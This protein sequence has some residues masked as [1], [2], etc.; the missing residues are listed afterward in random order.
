MVDHHPDS[1][2]A[3]NT[4]EDLSGVDI[5]AFANPYDALIQ[6]SQNDPARIQNFYGT[7]R[8]TRNEQ[9]RVKLLSPDFSGL[10][11]DPIL[12]KLTDPSIEPG[13]QDPR[14]CIVFWARPPPH[15]R[16]LVDKV[17]QELLALAPNLWV[18]PINN[19]HLTALE[20]T[21]SLTS[22]EIYS[23]LCA[24]G[25]PTIEAMTDY[26]YSHRARLIKP[27]ISYD[28]AA[29]A[30]SFLPAAGETLPS[31]ERTKEDD[32]F[33]YHHLRRD[34]FNLAKS[35]G[36]SVD[37]RY[38]VPS[39]HI[40]LGRFLTQADHDSPEKMRE[41]IKKIEDLNQWLENEWWPKEGEK[42]DGAKEWVVGMEKGLDCRQGTLWYG[43][44]ETVRLGKG[45]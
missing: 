13:F 37:S 31:G 27:M 14:Y 41:W 11:L 12:Q 7:H 1:V 35:T 6:S 42:R 19:L 38:V 30:L 18:M 16:S 5:A 43:D 8:T 24:L 40:T 44:G 36:V 39:S 33:T 26:P 4:F 29:L 17:Q 21:H 3:R 9:Q 22:P 32:A 23:I 25:S 45:F 2:D 15:I 28:G 20:I 10:I 34:L